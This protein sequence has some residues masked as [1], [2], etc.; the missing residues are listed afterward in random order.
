ME[1]VPKGVETDAHICN[2]SILMD[3]LWNDG[4]RVWGVLWICTYLI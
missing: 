3:V 4:L 1:E 2:F